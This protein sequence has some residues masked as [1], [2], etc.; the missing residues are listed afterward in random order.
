[1][2]HACG[3]VAPS[4][5]CCTRNASGFCSSYSGA[6]CCSSSQICSNGMCVAQT[7]TTSTTTTPACKPNGGTCSGNSDCCSGNCSNGFCC[8]SGQIGLSNGSCATPCTPG[9]TCS[10]PCGTADCFQDTSGAFYCGNPYIANDCTT[11][12][13]CPHSYFCLSGNDQCVPLC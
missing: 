12:S 13:N 8:A 6:A 1:L 7:T 11:D 3:S 4:S 10:G 9:S 5:I 2:C